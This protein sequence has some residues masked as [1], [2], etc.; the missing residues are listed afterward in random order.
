MFLRVSV[1]DQ[2]SV[3]G[4]HAASGL[5]AHGLETGLLVERQRAAVF[6]VL[7][8]VSGKGEC[9]VSQPERRLDGLQVVD[10]NGEEED[11]GAEDDE[12]E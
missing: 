5:A 2:V 7:E 11:Q 3:A 9:H 8:E 6:P 12:D 10:L 4:Q 1:A